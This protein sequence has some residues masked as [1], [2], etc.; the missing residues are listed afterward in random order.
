MGRLL[1]RSSKQRGHVN[2][3][4]SRCPDG[5]ATTPLVGTWKRTSHSI[6][7]SRVEQGGRRTTERPITI[8]G[9]LPQVSIV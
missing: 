1:T 5:D 8:M 9:G 7:P 2:S 4:S 3:S 6:F